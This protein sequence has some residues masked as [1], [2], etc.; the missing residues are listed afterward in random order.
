MEKTIEYL[1]DKGVDTVIEIGPGKALS[2][3][4]KKTVEGVTCHNIEDLEGLNKVI[5]LFGEK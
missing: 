2:G 5:E 4:V 1:K 3:F